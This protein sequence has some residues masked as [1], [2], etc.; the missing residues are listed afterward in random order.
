MD[1]YFEDSVEDESK[2]YIDHLIQN[3]KERGTEEASREAFFG[4]AALFE[5]LENNASTFAIEEAA[6][7]MIA[8]EPSLGPHIALEIMNYF[9]GLGNVDALDYW[10]GVLYKFGVKLDRPIFETVAISYSRS[11][12]SPEMLT[13][14]FRVALRSELKL[15]PNDYTFFI[16]RLVSVH[17]IHAARYI[18]KK[19][20]E[21]DIE[22]DPSLAFNHLIWMKKDVSLLQK[23]FSRI[24]QPT[25]AQYSQWVRYYINE[26]QDMEGAVELVEAMKARGLSLTPM[27]YLALMHGYSTISHD[28]EAVKNVF[29]SIPDGLR[30]LKVYNKYMAILAEEG[31]TKLI[32]HTLKLMRNDGVRPSRYTFGAL[33]RAFAVS[34]DASGVK[35]VFALMRSLDV[36][37][38]VYV[39]NAAMQ[40]LLDEGKVAEAGAFFTQMTEDDGLIPNIHSFKMF[41]RQLF[42]GER[43]SSTNFYGHRVE[44]MVEEMSEKYGVDPDPEICYVM[45]HYHALKQ[46]SGASRRWRLLLHET[47]REKIKEKVQ[48]ASMDPRNLFY[49]YIHQKKRDEKVM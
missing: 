29:H 8:S 42:K 9:A 28:L 6:R 46:R 38:D 33:V 30:D 20:V 45:M 15:R 32:I 18:V 39:Y 49:N 40:C 17:D 24:E 13:R 26:N 3:L 34:N 14:L 31:D 25:R 22:I 27:A 10:V 44:T 4:Q 12:V 47:T 23:Y 37:A 5:L 7:H 11:R 1:L 35:K 36:R 43:F 21:R 48:G 41:V 19:A 16:N 2:I